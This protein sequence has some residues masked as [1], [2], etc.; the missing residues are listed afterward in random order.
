VEHVFLDTV[1]SSLPALIALPV[2]V[3]GLLGFGAHRINESASED[4][5]TPLFWLLAVI[6]FF[7]AGFLISGYTEAKA[8]CDSLNRSSGEYRLQHCD[9]LWPAD[10]LRT[11]GLP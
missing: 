11:N 5:K 4:A 8:H 6:G 9:T 1:A 7:A 2:A 3:L 10:G